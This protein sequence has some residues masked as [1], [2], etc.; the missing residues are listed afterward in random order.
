MFKGALDNRHGA[1]LGNITFQWQMSVAERN[2]KRNS[3]HL[4]V[5]FKDSLFENSHQG[6]C[7]RLF[8]S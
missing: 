2:N 7:H 8:S 6:L 4:E 1:D 5:T 3:F